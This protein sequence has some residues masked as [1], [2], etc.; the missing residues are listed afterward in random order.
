MANIEDKALNLLARN[1]S[2]S[3]VAKACGVDESRISQ[4]IADDDFKKRLMEMKFQRYGEQ[5]KMDE[6]YDKMEAKLQQRFEQLIPMIQKPREVLDAMVKLNAMKRRSGIMDSDADKIGEVAVLTI[7]VAIIHKYNIKIENTTNRVI[8]A[9]GQPLLT[10]QPNQVVDANEIR[11]KRKGRE[12][13]AID[14]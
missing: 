6:S 10:A 12:V 5:A 3:D 7:P 2:Q 11:S 1:I 14:L 8:E 9:N 4:L 13:S